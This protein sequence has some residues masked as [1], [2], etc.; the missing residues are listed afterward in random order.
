MRTEFGV[1]QGQFANTDQIAAS[2]KVVFE[3]NATKA[4]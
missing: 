2:V 3:F 4:E 1:G